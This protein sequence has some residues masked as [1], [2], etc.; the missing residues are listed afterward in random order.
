LKTALRAFVL[1]FLLCHLCVAQQHASQRNELG[2]LLGGELIQSTTT[3]S[4]SA[5]RLGSSLVF[6]AAYDRHLAGRRTEFLLD[7]PF[8]AGPSHSVTTG[9]SGTITS[10]ATLY[11][12]PSLR[13]RF[14]NRGRVSPWLSGGFGYGLYEGSQ[15]LSGASSGKNPAVFQH[16]PTVQFGG[17]VDVRTPLRILLPVG[18][19]A[20]VR[21]YHT[22]D[23]PNFGTGVQRG[24]QDNVVAAGGFFLRF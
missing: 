23:T 20:E 19:R 1:T 11:V 13:V 24:G 21:D 9:Q 14:L 16:T 17:G 22:L 6:S 8:A 7:I 3:S 4:G 5:V 2:F 15:G 18:L 12:A 10:L